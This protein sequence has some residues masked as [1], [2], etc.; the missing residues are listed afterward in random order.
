MEL[1]I[2]IFVM[3]FGAFSIVMSF[4]M[5]TKNFRSAL[6][7][8]IVPFFGGMAILVQAAANVGI[9]NL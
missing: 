2:N 9:L 8:K 1:W 6:I 3:M 5:H 4:A 7:F